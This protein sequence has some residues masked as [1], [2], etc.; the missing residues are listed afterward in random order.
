M[1]KMNFTSYQA[2]PPMKLENRT[3][4]DK[5]ITKAPAWS[6]VDLRDGNQAFLGKNGLACKSSVGMKSGDFHIFTEIF[7][8]GFAEPT[9]TAAFSGPDNKLFAGLILDHHLMAQNSWKYKI[10]VTL[11]PH[12]SIGSAD[13]TAKDGCLY[14]AFLDGICFLIIRS[15]FKFFK[16]C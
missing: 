5:Q 11:L 10:P 12:F 4:P 14:K 1:K 13:S 16:A 2:Y 9:G 15:N 8:V 7:P 6:S 3:W